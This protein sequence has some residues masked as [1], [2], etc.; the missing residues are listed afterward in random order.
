MS[1][2]QIGEHV[3]VRA[4]YPRGHIR[5]PYYIRGAS[6]VIADSMGSFT[7]PEVAAVSGT[8]EQTQPLYR[9]RFVQ[10][11]AWSAYDGGP[12]DTLDVEIYEHW[13][14]ATAGARS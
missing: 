13:L 1:R 7:N 5:T 9:V 2:F 14:E 11:L 12:N 4:D 6:G 10:S 8:T 3:R